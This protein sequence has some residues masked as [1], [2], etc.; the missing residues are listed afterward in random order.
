LAKYSK[1]TV[2]IKGV[3]YEYVLVLLLPTQSTLYRVVNEARTWDPWA[4]L[5][6]GVASSTSK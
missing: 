2:V 3:N 4:Y 5:G 1:L 6:E